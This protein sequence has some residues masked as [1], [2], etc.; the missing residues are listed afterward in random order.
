MFLK[1]ELSN[2]NLLLIQGFNICMLIFSNIPGLRNCNCSSTNLWAHCAGLWQI[3]KYTPLMLCPG[4]VSQYTKNNSVLSVY[5][6]H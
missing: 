6:L 2:F 4:F 5:S 1:S 3:E